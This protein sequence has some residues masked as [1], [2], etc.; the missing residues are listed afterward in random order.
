VRFLLGPAGSGKTFRCLAEIR[1]T[2]AASVDGPPLLLV[3]PKQTTYQLERRLLSHPA[4]PG[5]TRLHILSFE[6]LADFVFQHLGQAPPA[7][8][9]EEGRLMVLRGLLTRRRDK[10]KLFRASARLNGFAQQ[11]SGTLRELQR[12]QLTPETL[13]DL[14]GQVP[15]TDGLALKLHDLATLLQDYLDWLAAHRLQDGDCLLD[16]ATEAALAGA[17][18][19]SHAPGLECAGLWVDGFAELSA[20]ELGLLA[21]LLPGCGRAT[22]TFC[23]RSLAVDKLRWL[24][25]WSVV[26]RAFEETRKR[27]GSVP[28]VTVSVEVLKPV[29]EQSRFVNSTVLQHL[30]AHWAEPQP[31]LSEGSDPSDGVQRSLRVALCPDPEAE[32]T[33]AA[34]EIL[35]HVRA[36]GRFREVMVLA[37]SLAD[38]HAPLRRVFARYEIPFFL[39]R[40]E[41]VTHHPLTELTRS[42]L[43]TVALGWQHEDWFAALKTGLMPARDEEIDQLEN[44]ALA[45]GWRGSVWQQPLHIRD[46]PKSKEDAARL[47]ELE[48]QLEQLRQKL[49]PPFQKLAL[50]LGAATRLSKPNGVQLAAALREFWAALEVEAQLQEWAAAEIASGQSRL[51]SS[52]HTTV[53]EQM[54]AWLANVELA[55]PEEALPVREWLPILEAGLA[56]LTV[57]VIPPALDQVLI[58]AMDRSRNPDIKLALLL[59]MNETVFPAPP[60]ANVL[61]TETDRSELEKRSINIG[62]TARQQLARERYYAYIACTRSRERLVF[63]HAAQDT[64]GSPLNP[65]PFLSQIHQLFPSVPFEVV[66]KH[67][68]W[69]ESEHAVDLIGPILR[70][71]N[72]EGR[73]Q[74]GERVEGGAHCDCLPS[75]LDPRPSASPSTL[76]TLPAL[77][78]VLEQIRH[79]RNPRL[80]EALAPELAQRLYG[81]VLRTSVS[82]MEQFAACP[83][84]FFVHSGLRAEERQLYEMDKREQGTFQHDALALFHQQLRA[85]GKRWRDITPAE[86]RTRMG[87][88][89]RGLIASYRDGLLTAS[90][91]SRF[92]ARVLTES[93]QDF[94]ETLVGW[95]HQQYLFDPVEVE[96]PFG[97]DENS[98]A[99]AI[100]LDH[101]HQLELYGR[102]DRV[103][104]YRTPGDDAAFCVVVDYKSGQKQLDALLLEHG[105]QLQ[106]LAYL[107]VLRRWPNPRKRFGVMRLVPAGV[108]YVG[109]RGKYEREQNRVAALAAVE[110]ARKLAYRHTGRFQ[111]GSLR[112]LD[113]REE[114]REGDQFSYRLTQNGQL[115]KR[116][117]EAL[118]PSAFEALLDSIEAN[119]VRMGREVFAGRVEVAPYRK[120]AATACDQCH[121]R[122][123][124]RIDPWTDRFRVLRKT[125]E[126]KA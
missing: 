25:N 110:E 87:R 72:D 50:T 51:P 121:Y 43:R 27:L 53:W 111:V 75:T 2:L 5:Y 60:E 104:L 96:L 71:Q 24:S 3:V 64:H 84:R 44:E 126:E 15:T 37:R 69:R 20:Q 88:I 36:G 117:H 23:L 4:L 12:N 108:F 102:I 94:V 32:A 65:S 13:T 19:A 123:I 31:Y 97:E 122:P 55:F 109:L 100:E 14:A 63:T 79:F 39:D 40:R 66:T 34:R 28:G 74:N 89:A 86:A 80:E 118:A 8:L 67:F 106:L 46:T 70:M 93:L 41:P 68:D 82:R 52:V 54:N 112:L 49:V 33:L 116:S 125:E 47:R 101:G 61:L 91:E 21:A 95:M 105:L 78:S 77:A 26:A 83:F 99:W 18:A 81:P 10:L 90:E 85:E 73:M 48:A 120:G 35:R 30:E 29:P 98:P 58:G 119:L 57:G 92:M 107:N 59:G 56:N 76:A 124:C 9:N 11:L 22:V 38:Y 6:R 7:L 103:D 114:V 17:K 42:A 16:A 1:E 62:A 113:A 45:H 115:D